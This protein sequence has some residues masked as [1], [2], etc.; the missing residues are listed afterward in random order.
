MEV[1]G[2][3]SPFGAVPPKNLA[4]IVLYLFFF[5]FFLWFPFLSV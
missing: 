5:F 3:A 2:A 1:A 4:G